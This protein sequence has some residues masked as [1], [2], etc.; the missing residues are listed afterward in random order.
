MFKHIK[1]T[2]FELI[3]NTQ[4]DFKFLF[5]LSFFFQKS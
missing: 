2:R 5:C 3:L 1:I 4:Q